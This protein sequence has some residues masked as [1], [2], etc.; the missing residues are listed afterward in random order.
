MWAFLV[1]ATLRQRI[2]GYAPDVVGY[3]AI[4]PATHKAER[5]LQVAKEVNPAI[6]AVLGGIYGT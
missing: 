4:T 6:V 3:T 1:D 5:L 2:A